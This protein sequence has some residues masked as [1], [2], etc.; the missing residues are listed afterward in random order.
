VILKEEAILK[1]RILIAMVETAKN[2]A[3][4]AGMKKMNEANTIDNLCYV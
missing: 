4:E 2:L 1:A 3:I